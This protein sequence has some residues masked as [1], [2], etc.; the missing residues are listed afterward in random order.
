MVEPTKLL[1]MATWHLLGSRRSRYKACSLPFPDSLCNQTSAFCA[2]THCSLQTDWQ[3]R[4]MMSSCKTVTPARRL[5]WRWRE[6]VS[7]LNM[8]FPS[9]ARRISFFFWS[10]E[11]HI[12]SKL[13][14]WWHHDDLFLEV[15]SETSWWT[16]QTQ[17]HRLPCKLIIKCCWHNLSV[18][19][20]V[21]SSCRYNCQAEF[22]LFWT[23]LY[24][25]LSSQLKEKK[26]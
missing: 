25:L 12:C 18:L 4:G 16:C 26:K 14:E 17:T 9:A 1:L 3:T 20:W 2:L 15:L 8:W 10:V 13:Q 21:C 22:M 24:E 6:D 5:T 11:S 19:V 7:I 23:L